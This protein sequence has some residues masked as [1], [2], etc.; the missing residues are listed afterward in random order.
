MQFVCC[1]HHPVEEPTV[2]VRQ[3]VVHIQKANRLPVR[4]SNQFRV[5]L[6]DDG[7]SGK[8]IVARQEGCQEDGGM[9]RLRPAH[10]QQRQNPSRNI[11]D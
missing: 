9:G 11:G 2:S 10:A 7:H 1:I 3:S 4:Q 5:N 6:I 8:G